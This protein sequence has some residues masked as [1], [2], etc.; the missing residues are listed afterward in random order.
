LNVCVLIQPDKYLEAATH[1]SLRASGALARIWPVWLPSKVGTRLEA[2]NEAGLSPETMAPYN[3]LARRLLNHEPFPDPDGRPIPHRATLSP[4][5][6]EARRI[7]HNEVERLMGEGGEL[8]DVADIASKAVSQTAKLALVL[9]LAAA[10]EALA[11]PTSEIGARTWATAQAVGT[12]FL[13]EAVRVQRLADEDPALEAARRTLRWLRSERRATVT[14]SDLMTIGP[15][16][17]P[18]ARQA[19]EILE[20][21]EEAG[22][23]RGEI[24]ANKR[25]PVYRLHPQFASFASFAR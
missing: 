17:R 9:H 13:S 25:R 3:A 8:A 19:V 15:R 2:P 24:G 6:R 14:A 4:E 12:W 7:F 20:R 23:L 1:P 16:P 11:R 18:R 22:W 21:L 5:A 10:P